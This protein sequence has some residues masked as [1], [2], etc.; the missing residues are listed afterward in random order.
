MTWEWIARAGG[1]ALAFCASVLVA[2]AASAQGLDIVTYTGADRS[3]RLLDG[4]RKEGALTL[5]S[6]AAAPDMNPQVAAFEKKYAIKVKVWRGSS[7]D[8]AHRIINEQR[9][10]RFEVDV[11]ETAGP[12]LEALVREKALQEVRTPVATDLIPE[13]TPAHRRWIMSRLSI[14]V[15]AYN[16][17]L[18]KAAEAPKTYGDLLDPRWK[19]KLAIEADDANWFMQLSTVMGEEKAVRL[20][21]DIVARNGIS[22]RKGHSLL[23]NLVPT[24]EVPVAL[25]VY[26]YRVEQLKNEAAP[27]EILYLPPVIA[28]PTGIAI[29]QK[30]P[31][32]FAAALFTDFFLTEGQEILAARG[33]TPTNPKVKALPKDLAL[34]D[35]PKFLDEGDKWTRLYKDLFSE[36]GR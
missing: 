32:P 3:Q 24:G 21:R 7:E 28:L 9:G 36:K 16:T 8:V 18:I 17:N 29:P 2:A 13:A 19:G 5:Y 20:F 22:V 31:H 25:T 11:A 1:I 33:N 30:A 6:S 12:D 10:G 4:A 27:V 14:F 15:A 23:A 26:A 34:I 35:L